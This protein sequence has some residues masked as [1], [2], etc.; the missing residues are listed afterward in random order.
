VKYLRGCHFSQLRAINHVDWNSPD[1]RN[2]LEK[3]ALRVPIVWA[4]RLSGWEPILWG[5]DRNGPFTILEG[6]HRLNALA[7]SSDRVHCELVTYV[8]LSAGAC[9]WHRPD[10]IP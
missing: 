9:G 4:G 5:H 8:G 2:E 7:G 6:N 1:D 3:V 10:S